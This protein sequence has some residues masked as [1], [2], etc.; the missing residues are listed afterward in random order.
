MTRST[1]PLEGLKAGSSRS[2]S[3]ALLSADERKKEELVVVV[4]AS[5]TAEA[6]TDFDGLPGAF[7]DADIMDAWEG[8]KITFSAEGETIRRLEATRGEGG[9]NRRERQ[10]QQQ[11]LDA[12]DADADIFRTASRDG[13][14][15]GTVDGDSMLA[16]GFMVLERRE[17]EKNENELLSLERERERAR[18]I[19][20]E[21]SCTLKRFA[22]FFV[23][24]H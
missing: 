24:S 1:R 19:V 21:Q 17:N 8:L 22:A 23:A 5:V 20:G 16:R 18:R 10:E 4:G 3:A 7:R 12:I 6:E 13:D 9:G 11:R 15:T 2:S 14:A